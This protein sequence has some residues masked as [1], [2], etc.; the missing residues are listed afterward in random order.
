MALGVPEDM[1]FQKDREP[2]EV[3]DSINA[4]GG[5]A[6]C[7]HPYWCGLTSA[8]VNSIKGIVAIEGIN[9]ATRYIGRGDSRQLWDELC[10]AGRLLPA[11]AVDDTHHSEDLFMSWTNILT[12]ILSSS[13]SFT[14]IGNPEAF[15]LRNIAFL[16]QDPS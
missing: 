7:A 6:I 12:V 15:W 9:T 1:V 10:D 8:Q 2:Q 5:V 3:V 11:V 4:V 14:P 13:G 16:H